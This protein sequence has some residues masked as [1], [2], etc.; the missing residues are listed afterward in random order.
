MTANGTYTAPEGKAYSPVEVAVPLPDNAYLLKEASG[1][2]VSFSDGADLP[3]PSFV[4]KIEA[5]QS[6]SGDPS[7]E[8]IRPISGH[9]GLNAWLRGKNLAKPATVTTLYPTGEGGTYTNQIRNSS[10][11]RSVI[12]E[13]SPN[14]TYTI[15]KKAGQR[16]RV[17][18]T[19]EEPANGVTDYGYTSND[20]GTTITVTSTSNAKYMVVLFYSSNADT[21]TMETILATLQIEIGETPT[22]YEP[23]NPASQTIQVSW[24]TESGEV[25]GG[26]VDLCSGVLTADKA[27]I[28]VTDESQIQ[29]LVVSANYGSYAILATNGKIDNSNAMCICNMGVS[30]PFND[31]VNSLYVDK[32]RCYTDD[33]GRPMIRAANTVSITTTT[34]MFNRFNGLQFVYK[35]ATP[36]TYQLTPQQIKSLLGNNNAWCS[37]G[38]VDIQYF[39]KEV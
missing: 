36:I 35:L 30:I 38:D 6:G 37:T 22:T 4:C 12:A 26:Y 11:A 9:T 14:T 7:P 29:G 18:F 33:L 32:D 15:S 8:N 2:L 13:A 20:T 3:M 27:Y 10:N 23:Y 39:A 24:Q 17:A 31:L 5:V 25:Y 16:F 19:E 21:D 28:T 1:A 34:E